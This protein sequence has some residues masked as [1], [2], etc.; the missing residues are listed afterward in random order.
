MRFFQFF[1]VIPT[2]EEEHHCYEAFY[3]ATSN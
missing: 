1:L 2:A 3:D